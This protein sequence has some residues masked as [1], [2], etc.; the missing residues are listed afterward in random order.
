[1]GTESLR[2]PLTG[3]GNYTLYLLREFQALPDIESV[4]CFDGN[5]FSPVRDVLAG[6]DRHVGASS[7]D[8]S[9]GQWREH[10]RKTVRAMPLAYRLK[11]AWS[12]MRFKRG[13]PERKDFVYHEPNFIFKPHEGPS[14]T[15]VHDLSFVRYPEFH[16]EERVAWLSRQLP[17]TLDRA[18]F[19]ITDSE[20]VRAEL[21]EQF[22]VPRDRVK[23]IYLGADARFIPRSAETTQAVLAKYGLV[24]GSY[25][26]FVGTIEP[27][28]GISVL[29]DAW[30]RLTPAIRRS[31]PLV[32]A[33]GLGW[34]NAELMSRIE[35]F[36]AQGEVKYLQFVSSQDL[37]FIYAGAATFVYPSVYEGFGLP[38]LEAMASGVPVICGAG[39]SMAEFAEG[40]CKLFEVGDADAL[41]LAILELVEDARQRACIAHSGI[42]QA[43]RFSWARCARET[44]KVY[45]EALD[46]N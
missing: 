23:A 27:R 28:K 30:Q 4:D 17:R 39:T 35:A 34:R 44:L 22:S 8:C 31:W 32:I 37:P 11:S 2:P 12:A 10:L 1:M 45:M 15:T 36:R 16:P 38:V 19:V 29:L 14:V 24:H 21:I 46:R 6:V 40:A 7:Y 43:Q 13:S 5:K 25:L 42:V 20:V 26:A 18:N 9:G 41:A 33:G 3:I